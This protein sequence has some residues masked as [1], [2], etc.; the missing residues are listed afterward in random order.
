MLFFGI[1][2]LSNFFYEVD[3]STLTY[4]ARIRHVLRSS[5]KFLANKGSLWVGSV[6]PIVQKRER[7]IIDTTRSIDLFAESIIGGALFD[8]RYIPSQHWWLEATTGLEK[9]TVSQ[10]GTINLHDSRVGL[11]DIVF[12][13]GYNMFPNDDT[14]ITLYGLAGFPTKKGVTLA[15]TFNTLVGTRFYSLGAGAEFS[16]SFIND[17]EQTLTGIFQARF[18]HFF[19]R[20]WFPILPRDAKI[21]PGNATDLLFTAQYR[22][23]GTIFETG[24]NPT[25]FTNQ[26]VLLKTGTVHGPNSVRNS[27]YASLTHGWKNF[28]GLDMPLIIG[29]GFS[30]G[31]SKLFDAK[32][33]SWWVNFTTVF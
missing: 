5:Q 25:F 11:D 28:P 29:T 31:R 15:E 27:I 7:H 6:V 30:I 18:L 16:Y 9:E 19:N 17:E 12:A 26:A 1:V 23:D 20:H 22:Y 2:V 8:I 24:Y 3:A 13:G 4:S 33:V 21:Q 10:R 14:Q 32:I